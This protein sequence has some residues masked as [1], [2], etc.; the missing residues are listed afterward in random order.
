MNVGSYAESYAVP[1]AALQKGEQ[2]VDLARHLLFHAERNPTAYESIY[3]Q[4]LVRK[5]REIVGDENA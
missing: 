1:T 5:A 3:G 2:A 4:D